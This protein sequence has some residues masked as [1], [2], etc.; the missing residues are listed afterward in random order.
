MTQDYTNTLKDTLRI[1]RM[2]ALECM[3]LL[4]FFCEDLFF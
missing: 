4:N 3:F 1:D 2:T